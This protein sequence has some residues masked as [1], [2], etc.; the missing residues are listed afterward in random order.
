VLLPPHEDVVSL[1][2]LFVVEAVG[3]EVFTVLT[4]GQ[5][6]PP[7]LFV[8]VFIRVPFPGE[9][10][11]FFTDNLPVKESDH[12]GVLVRQVLDLQVAAEVG[13]LL[14]HVLEHHLHVVLVA[15]GLLVTGEPGAVVQQTPTDPRLFGVEW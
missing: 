14:V 15:L 4:E 6:F 10:W 1:L 13:G 12:L 8:H 7:V 2:Q 9:E 3:I 11:M 5:E